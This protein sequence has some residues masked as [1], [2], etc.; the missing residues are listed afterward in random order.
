MAAKDYRICCALFS[1]YIGKVSKRNPNRML[2]DRKEIS[3]EEIL[4]LIDWYL[5]K[6]IDEA[7]NQALHFDSL[8]REGMRVE[9]KFIPKETNE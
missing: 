5:N 1:A 4:M 3:E 2:S 9:L 7:N 6:E 8:A